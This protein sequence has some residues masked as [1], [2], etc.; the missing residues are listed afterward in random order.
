MKSLQINAT[1]EYID[2]RNIEIGFR[3]Y[4][5]V[6]GF[7]SLTSN[8]LLLFLVIK[9]SPKSFSDYR[10]LLANTCINQMFAVL[11]SYFM[12]QRVLVSFDSMALLPIG[13]CRYFGPL[14]CF[15]SYNLYNG[16]QWNASVSILLSMHFRRSLI[17]M[18]L[19]DRRK[20]LQNLLIG[21]A[22]F[23]NLMAHPEYSLE[24]YGPIGGFVSISDIIYTMNTTLLFGSCCLMPILIFYW[25]FDVLKVLNDANSSF[26][27]R[28]K[29]SSRLMI[30]ALT[31]QALLPMTCYVPNVFYF[32]T[33]TTAGGSI[34][35]M[36]YV[37][38]ALCSFPCLA[39]PIFTIYFVAPF[40]AWVTRHLLRQK[41]SNFDRPPPSVTVTVFRQHSRIHSN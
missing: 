9:K 1:V 13:P 14:A 32:L 8:F 18:K 25:R 31:F 6:L 10:I 41:P 33:S 16:F 38:V 2:T 20:M 29:Q 34:T 15:V 36:E 28:T 26:S 7:S 37:I 11:N 30:H 27:E 19:V 24:K 21:Y 5:A 17:K 23:V 22:V 35:F 12:H 40:R 3:V 39:D 4:Y